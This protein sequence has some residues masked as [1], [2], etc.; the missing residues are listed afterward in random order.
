MTK[1][2]LGPRVF[3]NCSA[4]D[5]RLGGPKH[6]YRHVDVL[7]AGGFEAYALHELEGQ[8]LR[9]FENDTQVIARNRFDSIFDP[10]RDY[11]VLE[12]SLG[13]HIP[14]F[15]GRKVIFNKSIYIGFRSIGTRFCT[16]D[17]YVDTGV[18][19]VVAVS[20]HNA[21]HLR[22]AYPRLPVFPVLSS[23]DPN[24]FAYRPLRE[25]KRQIVCISKAPFQLATLYQMLR[26][27]THAG[28]NLL[29]EF[30]WVVPSTL[31]EDEMA[32]LLQDSLIFVFLA[33]EEGLGFAVL[34]AMACG[35]LVM[36]YGHGPLADYLPSNSR[37]AYSDLL[38]IARR[39]EQIAEAFPDGI[40][41]WQP[42]SEAGRA[43]AL[44]YSRDREVRSVIDAWN[45]IVAAPFP[46]T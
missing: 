18:V 42:L 13:S 3:F 14:R 10:S 21:D 16:R 27:R 31:C 4:T 9:W 40:D 15:A 12:E 7:N 35:C 45:Q 8:R 43:V 26:A 37:F 32:L 6:T 11:L 23:I 1:L 25:K 5:E 28:L 24:R 44:R 30:S 17:P 2:A 34:E 20:E 38:G 33:V 39:I 22:F 41:Q 29:G 46:R 19:A 36:A